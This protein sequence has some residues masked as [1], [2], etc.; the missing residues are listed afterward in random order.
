LE[1]ISINDINKISELVGDGISND[2]ILGIIS[3]D[4]FISYFILNKG[5][6]QS[7]IVDLIFFYKEEKNLEHI[8]KILE[9][10][11]DFEISDNNDSFTNES[12]NINILTV[13]NSILTFNELPFDINEDVDFVK[14]YSKNTIKNINNLLKK[15]KKSKSSLSVF[16]G[17]KGTG[18]TSI[19]KNLSRK[20]DKKIFFIPN[21][22][23]EHTILNPEFINFIK[24]N[25]NSILIMDD[26]E[27]VIDNYSRYNS[28][29]NNIIQMVD[30]LLS[31]IIN[32]DIILIFN[33]EDKLEIKDLIN[34]NNLLDIIEFEYLNLTEI[35]KLCSHLEIENKNEKDSKLLDIINNKK[36]SNKKRFGF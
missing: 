28:I 30:S 31:D 26:F 6:E 4:I 27:I 18:K 17:D 35:N 3:D 36:N 21:S 14:F 10:V 29:I 12:K 13:D 11:K 15:L 24:S 16:Y 1:K 23:I 8:N 9:N 33:T 32:V 2:R 25:N 22:M 20:L 34:C 5:T 19:I 7:I